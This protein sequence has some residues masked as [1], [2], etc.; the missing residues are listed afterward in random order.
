MENK[1]KQTAVEWLSEKLWKTPQYE[2]E[3]QKIIEQAKA[4]HKDEILI[5]Y[6]NGWEA[7]SYNPQQYYNEEYAKDTN[8]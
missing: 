8:N 5:A 2:T 3:W 1:P 6:D 7:V 4:M